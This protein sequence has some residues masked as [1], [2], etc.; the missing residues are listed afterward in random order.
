MHVIGKIIRGKYFDSVSLML[1]ARETL[2]LSGVKD[3]AAVMAT[4]ENKRILKT[5]G[6]DWP[7]L[8]DAGDTDLALGIKAE[9]EKDALAALTAAEEILAR[10]KPAAEAGAFQPRSLDSA[11]IEYPETNLVLISVAGRFAA[12]EAMKA[13]RAKRHVMLFSD[14]VSLADEIN[15]KQFASKEGLLVMGPDCGT[16]IIGGVPLAFANVVRRGTI[17]MVAASGTGLQEVSSLIHNLGCGISHGI[18][19]GGR[20][21]KSEVGGL[22]FLAALQALKDDPGTRVV[23]LVSKQPGP[24]VLEIIGQAIRDLGKPVV[25]VFLGADAETV[26]KSGAIPAATL[27]EA[28]HLAVALE[29]GADVEQARKDLRVAARKIEQEAAGLAKTAPSAGKY[30]RGL[31]CG[32]TFSQEAVF[33]LQPMLSDILSN[34]LGPLDDPDKSVGHTII[35][36]GG[37]EFTAGR[38]HP[39]ID[40]SLRNRRILEEA[41]DPETAVIL[42]DVVLGYGSNMTPAE[43]LTPVIREVCGLDAPP[44]VIFH[45]CGTDGDPQQRARVV[46]ALKDAGGVYAPSNAAAVTLAGKIIEQMGKGGR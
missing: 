26:R 36:L 21:I 14:N 13:L 20:D 42:L 7:E 6:M 3:A 46:Q 29:R 44:I 41:R 43:E 38:P 31:F 16:A 39:M 45:V 17:G 1:V 28:A 19:T 35:D 11:L 4:D 37:D 9:T 12:E 30:L 10:K 8:A 23:T 5:S 2:G 18:G 33:M 24:D 34:V 32:G 40:Y 22:T 25:A 27:E 15:L